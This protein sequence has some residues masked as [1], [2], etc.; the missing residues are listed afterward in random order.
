LG[1]DHS[2]PWIAMIPIETRRSK[3]VGCFYRKPFEAEQRNRFRDISMEEFKGGVLP[4]LLLNLVDAR[5]TDE[6]ALLATF[7]IV[8][9][10]F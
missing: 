9:G 6:E 2:I 1:G 5:R 7:D 3:R 4:P 10:E 8:I